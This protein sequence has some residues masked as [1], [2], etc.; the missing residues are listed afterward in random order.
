MK[1][2]LVIAILLLATYITMAQTNGRVTYV[3]S[4]N[5]YVKFDNTQNIHVDDTLFNGDQPCLKVVQKSSSSIVA[6]KIGSCTIE[7]E[8]QLTHIPNV[9]EKDPRKSENIRTAETKLDTSKTKTS[10]QHVYGRTSITSYSNLSNQANLNNHRLQYRVNLNIDNIAASNFSFESYIRY[11]QIFTNRDVSNINQ[12]GVF[13]LAL[14]Y[15]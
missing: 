1:K 13:N 9:Q 15:E 5:V 12:L 14:K 11:R 4:K 10:N 8:L 7:K 2:Y 3:T 6:N